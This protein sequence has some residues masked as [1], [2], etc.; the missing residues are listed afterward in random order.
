VV[1]GQGC[2]GADNTGV[3]RL[4]YS[5]TT[6]VVQQKSE[7]FLKKRIKLSGGFILLSGDSFMGRRFR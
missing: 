4:S 6:K 5:R 7:A 2:A 3:A 1:C